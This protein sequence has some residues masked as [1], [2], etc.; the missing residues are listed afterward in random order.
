M[1]SNCFW[2]ANG[3]FNCNKVRNKL[4]TDNVKISKR[5]LKSVYP[6]VRRIIAIGDIHGDLDKLKTIFLKAKLIKKQKRGQYVWT[7]E[8]TYVVQVGDQLDYGGRGP[9]IDASKELS[10]LLFMDAMDNK[11][12]RHK[13]RV[14]SLLGNHELMNVLGDFRYVSRKGMKD[15]GGYSERKR[16]FTPGGKLAKYL[17]YNRIG[18]VQIGK[19][20]FVHG[21]L[22][23]YWVKNY[24]L[25]DL[26]KKIREY[27][28]GNISLEQ[29]STL[30]KIIT[31]ENSFFWTRE[32]GFPKDPNY[33][34]KV[35][36][37]L[38]L[39]NARGMVIGH[40]I[41]EKITSDCSNKL[42]KIDVALSRAFGNVS[43]NTQCLEIIS[44]KSGNKKSIRII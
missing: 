11:A 32:F 26:N 15:F 22:L 18:V 14:I 23:P 4:K 13:G 2:D 42:W 9:A 33:C 31:G 43:K 5:N 37:T 40:S 39:L 3:T 29:D 12:R 36:K 19:W 8:D 30:K 34:R 21:G 24:K 1:Y 38:K 20:V 35:N 6:A 7:G 10:V 27:L 41:H 16:L 44:T 25:Q 28:L 17:A